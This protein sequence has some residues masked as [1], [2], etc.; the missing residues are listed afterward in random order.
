MFK[1]FNESE[2]RKWVKWG[3]VNLYNQNK[4]ESWLEMQ[5]D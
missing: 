3:R 5:I 4:R 2:M 1:A